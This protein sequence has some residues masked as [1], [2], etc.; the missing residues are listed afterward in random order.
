M[1]FIVLCYRTQI[2]WT[3]PPIG[4][5]CVVFKSTVIEHKDIWYTDEGSLSKTFCEEN[6]NSEDTQPMILDEC[7]AC[8]EAKY[9][10]T[11]EGLWSRHTHPKDFPSNGWLTKFSDVIG[12]SH[13]TEYRFW[14]YGDAA[15]EGVKEVAEH[16][17]T[18]QLE[19]ELKE[20][21][22]FKFTRI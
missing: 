12:A 7:K 16:G 3:A 18:R 14:A 19:R 22:N 5:G 9:E 20:E 6:V 2:T 11:F 10:L 15:S 21:V 17:S 1:N 13:T 8:D 4:S